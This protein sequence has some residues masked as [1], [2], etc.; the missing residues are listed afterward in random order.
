MRGRFFQGGRHVKGFAWVVALVAAPMAALGGEA[1]ADEPWS[2]W[3][4][5]GGAA[6]SGSVA[7]GSAGVYWL[8]AANDGL[9]VEAFTLDSHDMWHVDL[10]PYDGEHGFGGS[11][12]GW[13]FAPWAG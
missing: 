1:M 11:A 2:R 8:W 3:R 9:R 10:G 12:A 5:A 4:G 6:A 7:A 13:W